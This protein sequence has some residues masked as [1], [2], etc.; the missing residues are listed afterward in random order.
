MRLVYGLPLLA[1]L[2]PL[3]AVAT[4][5]DEAAPNAAAIRR[6]NAAQP[7]AT[8]PITD[9]ESPP[10][11]DGVTQ[12]APLV[13]RVPAPLDPAAADGAPFSVEDDLATR[14][15]KT[16][17]ARPELARARRSLVV[18]KSRFVLEARVGD[19]PLRRYVV[20]LGW[21]PFANKERMGD[22]RTPEG[23][24]Y[25]RDKHGSVY[26]RFLGLSYPASRDADRGL[27]AGSI[28]RA[29]AARLRDDERAGRMPDHTTALGGA[30]GIHGGGGY[31]ADGD[32]VL[33]KT[34]TF[35][36]VGLRDQDVRELDG[37][38]AL[39]TAVDVKR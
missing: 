9:E 4:R 28:D 1:F 37:F 17:A 39:G 36:C 22:G 27:A 6:D 21:D 35:G 34:W 24:Y 25:I 19:Q 12:L 30:V 11:P 23:R 38:A 26:T 33:L 8:A 13:Y 5:R 2:V 18:E 16:L 14:L 15:R 3:A 7:A 29:T 20:N 32:F 10:L 31:R